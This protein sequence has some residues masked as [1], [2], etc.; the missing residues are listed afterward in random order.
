MRTLAEGLSE[1]LRLIADTF[2]IWWRN[3]LPLMTWYL[4]GYLG[5]RLSMLMAIWLGRH[6]HRSLAIGLFSAGVLFQMVVLVAMIRMLANSLYRWRDATGTT[7]G[8]TAD[9]N[10]QRLLE[11]LS[12]TL[13]PIVAVYSAWG[14]LDKQVKTLGLEYTAITGFGGDFILKVTDGAWKDFLPAIA[15]LLIARRVI[16]AIDDRWPSR[17]AKFLQVWSEAFFLLLTLIVTPVIAGKVKDWFVDRRFWLGLSDRWGAVKEWFA[18]IHIPVPA[19]IEWLWGT[20]WDTL[21]PL[22]KDGVGEPLTW[23]AIT[24]VVFGHRALSADA[25]LGGTRLGSRLSAQVPVTQVGRIGAIAGKAPDLVL[26][27]LKEKFYPTLNAFRLLVRV[28]PVYLGVVCLVYTIYTLTWNWSYVWVQ[29][30]LGDPGQAFRLSTANLVDLIT[31]VVFETLRVAL[32]AAAFD[33]CISVG[34]SV[35]L[36]ASAAE[37]DPVKA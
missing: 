11:L 13:L 8:E 35:Q 3:L 14:F 37:S 9:P 26:G 22:F 29:R 1:A 30:W 36:E 20:F 10:Q 5:L 28:G 18:G 17:P 16:E 31:N 7:G 23:L 2:R 25:L 6:Q 33:Q 24:T 34:R 4:T 21:W 15:I 19:G 32:L 27:G 12:I